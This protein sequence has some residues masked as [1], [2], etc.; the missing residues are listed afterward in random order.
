[1]AQKTLNENCPV[2]GNQFQEAKIEFCPQCHWEIIIISQ[3]ASQGLKNF[4][5]EKLKRHKEIFE[6]TK[7]LNVVASVKAEQ[8]EKLEKLKTE[9]ESKNKTLSSDLAIS[10]D[11]LKKIKSKATEIENSKKKI[12][13]LEKEVKTLT[14][15]LKVCRQGNL[16]ERI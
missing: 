14:R 11:E 10:N 5:S 1:M 2:C 4:Y 13:D 15:D 7:K 8:I 12:S 9:L 6:Q 16:D 3:S